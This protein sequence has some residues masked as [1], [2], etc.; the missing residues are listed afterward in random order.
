MKVYIILKNQ[1]PNGNAS[2][3]RVINYCKGLKELDIDCC[4]IL[5][6]AMERFEEKVRNTEAFGVF[7]GI[8]FQYISG[9][10]KRSKYLIKR[11]IKDKL[12]YIKTLIY[13]R[14]NLTSNDIVIIYEGG[15]TWFSMLEKVIHQKGAKIIMELNELPYGTSSE[16]PKLIHLRDKMLKYVFPKIDGYISISETLSELVHK[17]APKSINIKVPI[18]VDTSISNNVK[19]HK[20]KRPYIFH[21]GSLYE[22]KDGVVGMLTAFALANKELNNSL[23]FIL[24]GNLH[25]SRDSEK[26][27]KVIEEYNIQEYVKFV[28]YLFTNELREYQMGA[29]MMIINKYETLQNKYCFSTKLGEY[30]AFSKPIIITNVGEAMAYINNKKNAYVVEPNNIK[31]MSKCILEII[32]CPQEAKAIGKNGFELATKEFNY[33]HQSKRIAEFLKRIINK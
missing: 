8:P 4:V 28:G 32:R 19:P 5:P 26:I 16:T 30:L 21:S 11:Q 15:C 17:Y 29:S 24:T 20:T 23:D 7:E 6:I 14:K 33:A 18:I 27:K 2:T 1:F 9:T 12:D 10:P 3:A 13:L 25:D 22:Q 31:E